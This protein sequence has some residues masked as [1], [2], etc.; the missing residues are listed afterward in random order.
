M[1]G[2]KFIYSNCWDFYLDWQLL[3][4]KSHYLNHHVAFMSCYLI[5]LFNSVTCRS[6]PEFPS[7]KIKLAL[8]FNFK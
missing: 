8:L 4:C 6:V 1:A 3:S 5:L 7:L 2:D